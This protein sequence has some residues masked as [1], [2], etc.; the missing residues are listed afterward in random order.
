MT[1]K[2]EV[3]SAF[4]FTLELK[5]SG[6]REHAPSNISDELKNKT[7]LIAEDNMVNAIVSKKIL[8]KWGVKSDHALNGLETVE[9]AK[10]KKFDFILMDIHM[11]EMNGFEAARII[12]ETD[13]PNRNTPIYALTADVTSD[14]NE[15]HGKYF[16]SI[17][18][19]PIEIDKLFEA[20]VKK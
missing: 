20:L 16:N 3:G 11:P 18:L 15:E 4:Y 2:L 8:T 17:L 13:N 19:K 9:M 6:I 12:R 7:T 5:K 10:S 14:N 1:V